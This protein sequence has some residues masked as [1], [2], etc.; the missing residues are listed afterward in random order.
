[1]A[2][3]YQAPSPFGMAI[4]GAFVGYAIGHPLGALLKRPWH[5][6]LG[7]AALGGLAGYQLQSQ[8]NDQLG[9]LVAASQ[10]QTASAGAAQLPP[11]TPP[12]SGAPSTPST[13]SGG[14][15]SAQPVAPSN[16]GQAKPVVPA[17][18]TETLTAGKIS[19]S[20]P[21]GSIRVFNTGGGSHL[22]ITSASNNPIAIAS[23]GSS[24]QAT[25]AT[26]PDTLAFAWTD[27]SGNMQGATYSVSS[28]M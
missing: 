27:A 13:P 22:S 15:G 1:M 7:G 8:I 25:F 4:F 23:D 17:T 21:T 28:S 6:A 16:P 14:S 20:T 19:E 10:A 24:G 9:Q 26:L 11:S 2:A 3:T 5:G 12:P 18:F